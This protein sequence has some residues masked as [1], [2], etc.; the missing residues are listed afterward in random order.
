MPT[1]FDPIG[2][3]VAGDALLLRAATH[4]SESVPQDRDR[5]VVAHSVGSLRRLVSRAA[6]VV[7]VCVDRAGDRDGV[8]ALERVARRR[9]AGGLC[10]LPD[11]AV[12]RARIRTSLPA[13]DV[14]VQMDADLS[15]DP[16]DLE[17]LRA[18]D[19]A[20]MT[21]TG[22]GADSGP[23]RFAAPAERGERTMLRSGAGGSS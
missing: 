21:T 14:L 18:F 6:L 19:F 15:H 17:L 13:A 20:A 7:S 3:T 9:S 12:R 10:R 16:N 5:G 2:H 4:P 11:D 22:R 8:L 23:I 1:Q